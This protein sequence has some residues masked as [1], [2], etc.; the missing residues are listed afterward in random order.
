MAT[1]NN[2]AINSFTKGM[3][4]DSSYPGIGE[5]QYLYAE[6]IRN[7]PL[8]D[9]TDDS[10]NQQGSIKTI[11]GYHT[12][13]NSLEDEF[14][15][16]DGSVE[17][18]VNK[19]LAAQTI[20]NIGI[21]I[22]EDYWK[23][24]A[25]IRFDET[26]E[27]YPCQ[28]L[29]M[30]NR[31]SS[32]DTKP[33][34]QLSGDRASIVLTWETED[35]IKLYIADGEHYMKIFNVAE[36]NDAY[37]Y[38]HFGDVELFN[39]VASVQ[40]LPIIFCGLIDGQ[41]KGGCVQ[42]A[43]RFYNKRGSVSNMSCPTKIIP[44]GYNVT[45]NSKISKASKGGLKED[46]L[47]VGVS[48]RIPLESDNIDMSH[49]MIY[50]IHYQQS[51]QEPTIS[52][53][54]DR[55]VLYNNDDIGHFMKY[56]DLGGQSLQDISV[57]EFNSI[58]GIHI[59]PKILESKNDR[60]FAANIKDVQSKMNKIGELFDAKTFRV[61]V[62]NEIKIDGNTY[63]Y[64]DY[65]K[66]RSNLTVEDRKQDQKD[67]YNDYNNVLKD[68]TNDDKPC[69]YS[70]YPKYVNPKNT[71]DFGY[72]YGGSG[73]YINWKFIITKLPA[74]YSYTSG[75]N[76]GSS[77]PTISLQQNNSGDWDTCTNRPQIYTVATHETTLGA[78]ENVI[79]PYDKAD[80]TNSFIPNNTNGS[81][82]NPC[83]SY[84]FKS[85]RRNELYRYGI[86]LYNKSGDS[87]PVLWIDDIRTPSVTEYGFETFCANGEHVN[88]KGE[89]E[90]DNIELSVMPMGI[91]FDVN[92]DE[93]NNE[94]KNN[95]EFKDEYD[96]YKV[97]QYEIVRCHRSDSDVQTVAQGVL[98]RPIQNTKNEKD[99]S[100]SVDQ[101][102]TPSGILS[103]QQYWTGHYWVA[104][105]TEFT[106]TNV[107]L[108][109]KGEADNFENKT[110]F[111][112]ICPEAVYNREYINDF[113]K[114][115][116]T[117]LTP[118]NYLFGHHKG[119]SVQD[120][121]SYDSTHNTIKGAL[122]PDL[123][124]HL[125]E[126]DTQLFTYIGS[127]ICGNNLALPP[128][129]K[130]DETKEPI[131]GDYYSEVKGFEADIP[132]NI[133]YGV[134]GMQSIM[135]WQQYGRTGISYYQAKPVN[136]NDYDDHTIDNTTYGKRKY[137]N[138]NVSITYAIP[139]DTY[140]G[141]DVQKGHIGL[142]NYSDKSD[143]KRLNKSQ[144]GYT[145][146]YEQ[147][148]TVYNRSYANN[149][150]LGD[151][152]T[153][154]LPEILDGTIHYDINQAICANPIDW[155]D[156]Y[157]SSTNDKS[158]S[159]SAKYTNNIISCGT[160]TYCNVVT[161]GTYN[162]SKYLSTDGLFGSKDANRIDFDNYI[163]AMCG[164]GGSCI[165]LDL[166]DQ[167]NILYKNLF[168]DVV[169]KPFTKEKEIDI[170]TYKAAHMDLF[171][172]SIKNE[173]T[174]MLYKPDTTGEYQDFVDIQHSFFRS[175]ISGTYL[176]NLRQNTIPYG[177]SDYSSRTLNTYVSNGEIRNANDKHAYVFD[178]DCF[179][180]P[181]EYVSCHKYYDKNISLPATTTLIYAIPVETNINLAYTSG[182]EFSR[183]Y[184]DPGVSNL[185]ENIANVNDQ[186]V[187]QKPQYEY[188]SVYSIQSKLNNKQALDL[189][190]DSN[191]LDDVDY[192]CY[193]SELKSNNENYDN[194]QVFR[195]ANYLDVDDRYGGIT[196]LRTFDNR[197]IFWQDTAV[198][199]FSVN[200]RVQ[201]SDNTGN[202]LTL[203]TG[204][205]LDRYDYIDR[206]SG[207]SKEM[208][209]DT[210]S[211]NTLYWYDD[212]NKEIKR[213]NGQGL[214]QL[215]KLY[216]TQN[217]MQTCGRSN[218]TTMLY[219]KKYNEVIS[220][221]L[222]KDDKNKSISYN[223]MLQS[224]TSI[225]DI[226]FDDKL[227]LSN[228][229]Y[230]L[231]CENDHLQI[232]KWD[233]KEQQLQSVIKYTVNEQPIVTKVF[234]NQ[235][236]VSYNHENDSFNNCT[237]SWETDICKKTEVTNIN[238]TNREG[239][240]R[241]AI[242]RID[243]FTYGNRY[244]GK[245]MV[246]EIHDLYTPLSYV[247]TKFR[248]SCS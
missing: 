200:E 132:A 203:G 46:V 238:M 237:F 137:D 171:D 202:P 141:S 122:I 213:L 49:I 172:Y 135:L 232:H 216:G 169:K 236:L 229:I 118:V 52:L 86:I 27:E 179:I 43:Y 230:L 101:T 33:Q 168:T 56:N 175:S 2:T 93:F 190:S 244:R 24:W 189:S 25:I 95:P 20:R 15:T 196:H 222:N 243:N 160:R 115:H 116:S 240:F 170:H 34:D 239:N 139:A 129:I 231:S 223:E 3:N 247:I 48:L 215:N 217:I 35:N 77:S 88:A 150:I 164:T 64:D 108:L 195:A 36:S 159:Y 193:Y 76:F 149:S 233:E 242:P 218:G 131:Y 81:Y 117:Y 85:L 7:Y 211:Q 199:E 17:F 58:S 123:G 128:Q 144:F 87:T 186:L 10:V 226:P 153:Y 146:L 38:A 163:S 157:S 194:W 8:N 50:R 62:D 184:S 167:D 176:C 92:I 98:S 102:F 90:P 246:C 201:I 83:V 121:R 181:F 182:Y 220:S 111:Q 55:K 142:K 84:Q 104:R 126:A 6:N 14:E 177:G 42:Y 1:E 165:L 138:K 125:P 185:Q 96:Y 44:L 210:Y 54:Y 89:W 228:N 51:G 94:I 219:D 147:S 161:N 79:I 53:I 152:N 245:F 151:A 4:T 227:V 65:M 32:E 162:N 109:G 221:V 248:K 68:F 61:N 110:L 63:K 130:A 120:L 66:N 188:N 75:D 26:N 106:T 40:T 21:I 80:L 45:N 105:S 174:D 59:I 11:E 69:K 70:A 235:E 133:L 166:K 16:Y 114:N 192:R 74:D 209:C 100:S 197:L 39:Q 143:L 124:V 12:I 82:A 19:I 178:G 206:Q 158:T 214:A 180:Q 18:H 136:R 57:E 29:F 234:D 60:L 71:S 207:M 191:S 119:I 173:Y 30:S 22:V 23:N 72:Y 5:G 37:N 148:N 145:K 241:Y 41:L 224:F 31:N 47:N 204:G 225:Y 91:L 140:N 187:Q 28:I 103:T 212:A 112:F 205:V 73:K 107:D 183:N 9:G 154:E 97:T 78:Y 155:N 198:G 113:L 127:S 99:G 208:Y 156:V 67:Y 134:S 13:F